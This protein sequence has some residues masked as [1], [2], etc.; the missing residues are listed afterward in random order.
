MS[1]LRDQTNILYFYLEYK[2][3][4]QSLLLCEKLIKSKNYN[5]EILFWRAVSLMM[6][7]KIDLKLKQEKHQV[8]YKN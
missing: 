8:Q 7:G 3:Y 6:E 5:D 2:Y 1:D 4:H